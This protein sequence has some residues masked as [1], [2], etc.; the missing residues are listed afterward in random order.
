MRQWALDR[1]TEGT[2]V[3][4]SEELPRLKVEIRLEREAEELRMQNEGSE[5]PFADGNSGRDD[6]EV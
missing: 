6:L 1:W 5:A 4:L 2:Q 3:N